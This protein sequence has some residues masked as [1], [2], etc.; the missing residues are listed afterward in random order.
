LPVNKPKPSLPVKRRGPKTLSS[1]ENLLPVIQSPFQ[2]L[3]QINIVEKLGEMRLLTKELA[4]VAKQV[5][6]WFD[7]IHVVSTGFKDKSVLTDIVSAISSL[8]RNNT[9]NNLPSNNYYGE[10]R[11]RM[12]R[13]EVPVRQKIAVEK[14]EKEEKPKTEIPNIMDLFNNPAFQQVV[15]QLFNAEKK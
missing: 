10:P 6:Q 13:E 3:P 11:N 9:A 4:S 2:A 14:E 8:A 5:E 12:E 1:E 15:K 7:V